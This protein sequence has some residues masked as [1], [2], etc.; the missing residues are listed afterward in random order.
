MKTRNPSRP[1][2]RAWPSVL[3]AAIPLAE[4][5]QQASELVA[6]NARQRHLLVILP[7]GQDWHGAPQAESDGRA[8]TR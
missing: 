1:S 3:D 2:I 4:V 8:A 5:R 7:A 6:I